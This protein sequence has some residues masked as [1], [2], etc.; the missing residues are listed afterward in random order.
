MFTKENKATFHL[1]SSGYLHKSRHEKSRPT[2]YVS[3][4][5]HFSRDWMMTGGM[6]LITAVGRPHNKVFFEKLPSRGRRTIMF[7]GLKDRTA[8]TPDKYSI[9]S[10]I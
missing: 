6:A 8:V 4:S 7:D 3:G 1:A 5:E 2:N 9:M 10:P